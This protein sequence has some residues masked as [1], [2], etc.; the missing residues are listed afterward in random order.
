MD[1]VSEFSTGT[2]INPVQV[3]GIIPNAF[4]FLA[5]QQFGKRVDATLD[6][7]G[8][9]SYLFPIY[10]LAYRFG[11]P[12][13]LNISAGY[14]LPVSERISAR[15]Y[16]RVANVLDQIYYEEGFTTPRCGPSAAY[17]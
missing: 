15:F 11:G 8:G 1:R 4:T 12:H 16:V 7:S 10:G 9:R 5:A 6:F 17:D 14:T 2:A 13:T 3:P